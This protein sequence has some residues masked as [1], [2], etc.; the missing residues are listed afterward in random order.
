[1]DNVIADLQAM[2]AIERPHHLTIMVPPTL[3]DRVCAAI[4]Q[5]APLHTVVKSP[6]LP[7]NVVLTVRTHKLKALT[8][9]NVMEYRS[10]DAT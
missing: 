1:M 6:Y 4:G 8:H 9:E 10:E 7:Q 2:L 3:Y 5:D